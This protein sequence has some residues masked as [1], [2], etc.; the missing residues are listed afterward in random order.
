[1]KKYQEIKRT[2]SVLVLEDNDGDFVLIEDYLIETFRTVQIKRCKTFSDYKEF[3]DNPTKDNIN[4]ILLDLHLPD[5]SGL[6]LIQKIIAE[7]VQVPV[8][9]LTGYTD[10]YLAKDS[11]KLGIDDFLVKDEVTPSILHKSIEFAFSRSQYVM[12]IE[13]Q[14]EKLRKIAWTQSHVVRA[15]L[16]RILGIINL[17]ETEKE[18]LDDLMFWLKQLRI[19]SNEMDAVVKK[20]TEEAQEIQLNNNVE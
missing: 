20:I 5:L 2:L 12:H 18:K 16:A 11:L 17:I 8:I 15:P 4:L 10:L 13:A 6:E 19:S 9:I 3:T 1:M 14:N 7:N